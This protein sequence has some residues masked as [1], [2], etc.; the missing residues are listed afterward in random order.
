MNNKNNN[1]I[2]ILLFVMLVIY[3]LNVTATGGGLRKNSIKTCPDG[4]TYGLHSDGHGG[5]HWHV[6][7]TN[8]DN[9]YS[10]GEA[11]Y[12]DPCPESKKNYGTAGQTQGST[13]SSNYS[14]YNN[15]NT[16]TNNIQDPEPE[17]QKSN[18]TSIKYIWIDGKTIDDIKDSMEFETINKKIS[19][20]VTTTDSK[21][22]S[23]VNGNL[24]NLVIDEINKVEIIVTAEDGSK[25][26][27]LLNIKRSIGTNDITITEFS[28]NDSSIDFDTDKKGTTFVYY[29]NNKFDYKYKLSDEN[30]TIKLM[31]DGK[32]IKNNNLK[33]GYNNYEI[34]IIDQ[35]DNINT[36]YLEIERM[37][38]GGSIALIIITAGLLLIL[39]VAAVIVIIIV[40][41]RKKKKE[42]ETM[43][44]DSSESIEGNQKNEELEENGGKENE[45]HLDKKHCP[46]CNKQLNNSN[47]SN[48]KFN[49]YTICKSCIK[50]INEYRGGEIPIDHIYLEDLQKIVNEKK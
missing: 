14:N 18:D 46:V 42:K 12:S 27:Y 35:N 50:K 45:I 32:E 37:S 9:Y 16:E 4:V 26:T 41:K 15:S 23:E 30:A 44:D 2:L 38:Q 13:N 21:A 6:A 17:P 11:I 22:K 7:V 24:E 47:K 43:T 10:S 39:P 40:L 20:H 8:G 3:P 34:Q 48:A 36:Y 29:W 33:Q 25:K 28:I 5:T 49:E 19:M 1:Y 31:Q